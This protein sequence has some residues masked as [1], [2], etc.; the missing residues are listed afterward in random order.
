MKI[1]VDTLHTNHKIIYGIN[2]CKIISNEKFY[3]QIKLKNN[4]DFIIQLTIWCKISRVGIF[5]T[6]IILVR[7]Y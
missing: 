3:H 6:K 2:Y 5:K 1:Q 7:I 4:L